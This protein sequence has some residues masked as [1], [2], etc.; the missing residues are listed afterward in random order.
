M[1]DRHVE[2]LETAL[3]LKFPQDFELRIELT[4]SELKQPVVGTVSAK[5]GKIKKELDP[6]RNVRFGNVLCW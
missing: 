2:A 1:G 6:I 4:S 3:E 5:G